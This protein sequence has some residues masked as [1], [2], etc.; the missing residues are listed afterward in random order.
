M[1]VPFRKERAGQAGPAVRETPKNRLCRA[2][3]VA[4][5]RGWAATRSEPTWG[6]ALF[7]DYEF[8]A[9]GHADDGGLLGVV[10]G[11]LAGL[12]GGAAELEGAGG[13]GPLG[14]RQRVAH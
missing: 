5:G 11:R 4:P 3:G 13:T 12:V 1:E 10:A 9:L 8:S 6:R 14:V 2:S 7:S